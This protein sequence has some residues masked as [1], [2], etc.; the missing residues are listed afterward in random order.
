M[1]TWESVDIQTKGKTGRFYVVCPKCSSDRKKKNIPCLT[2]NDEVGNRWWK[3]FSGETGVITINGTFSIKSL[4]GR[5]ST[6][7]TS[8]G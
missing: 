3:C 8:N 6:L 2:V 1:S 4:S 5:N 7:L